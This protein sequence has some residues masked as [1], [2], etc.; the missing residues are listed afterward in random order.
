MLQQHG[1]GPA[2]GARYFQTRQTDSQH[3]AITPFDHAASLTVETVE[4]TPVAR[5]HMEFRQSRGGTSIIDRW[6]L[7]TGHPRAME[8]LAVRKIRRA[9]ASNLGKLKLLLET[10]AVQLQDGR[11]VSVG[12]LAATGAG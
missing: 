11:R 7:A 9:V 10:G 4:G 6:D 8:L 12:R 1:D 3:T 2:A 5:R